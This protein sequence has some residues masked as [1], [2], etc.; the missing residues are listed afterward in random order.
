MKNIWR[1]F[2]ISILLTSVYLQSFSFVHSAGSATLKF[3]PETKNANVNDTIDLGA[4]VDAGSE[5]I[6][7]NDA[8]IEYDSSFLEF[9]SVQDGDFFPVVTSENIT[10]GR[11]Y[12]GA[13]VDD[14]ATSK[15]GTGTY[16]TVSFKALQEGTTTVK[17]FCDDSVNETSEVIKD[18]ID[19]TN[20][21]N[22]SGNGT[23]VITIGA[24]TDTVSEPTDTPTPT[25]ESTS[26]SGGS[27]S[28]GGTG[29]TD[30]VTELPQ[31]GILDSI[32]QVSIPG[33]AL[34]LIGVALKLLL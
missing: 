4:I 16:A 26:G 13:Y 22:C 1:I 18:D 34:L 33:A 20:V 8:Y 2:L 14:P 9:Q 28:T 30:N 29:T 23:A 17:Y 32:L 21:I 11:L 25:T 3:D 5:N 15:T 24:S 6:L 12:I 19:A 10:P 27:T 31:S 7:S